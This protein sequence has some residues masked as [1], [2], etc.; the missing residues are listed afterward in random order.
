MAMAFAQDG[1]VFVSERTGR[2]WQIQNDTYKL[3]HQFATAPVLGHHE[4]GLIGIA[5]DP[6][7]A[8]NDYIYCYYTIGSDAKSMKNRVVR[9]KTSAPS[10]EVLL[11]DI[12]AGMIHDGGVVAFAPDKTLYIGVGVDDEVQEHAQD[13]NRLDGKVLRIN[14]DGSI[15]DDNPI[16][17]SPVFSWGHRNIFGIAFHP[18]TGTG[19]VCDVGPDKYDEINVLIKGANYGWPGEMGPSKNLRVVDPIKSY[20]HVITPTQCTV[21]DNCLYFGGYNDG[22]VRRLTLTGERL[23]TVE[24]EEVVYQGT[25]FGIVG[26]FCG[27]DKQFFVTT[28]QS[29][30]NITSKMRSADAQPD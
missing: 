4:T 3:V 21:V 12:P 20:E 8:Q 25:P 27:P 1:R 29:I 30:I 15:P 26:V 9:L 22:L 24:K 14:R 2:L 19:F 17:G 28:P 16:K 13:T 5:L 11:D 23:D 6:D 10:E 18:Q 7:F